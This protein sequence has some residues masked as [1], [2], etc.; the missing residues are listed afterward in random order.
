MRTGRIARILGQAALVGLLGLGVSVGVSV[1]GGQVALADG[2]EWDSVP[3]TRSGFE[4]DS[5]PTTPSG[6][7][8]D[9]APTTS[10]TLVS[11]FA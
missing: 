10:T 3:T 1:A 8:W 11:S 5:V 9:F 2:F 7:E 6:F 4:W